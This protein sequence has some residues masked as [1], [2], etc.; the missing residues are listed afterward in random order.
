MDGGGPAV[1]HR[2]IRIEGTVGQGLP[3][4]V[5]RTLAQRRNY[6]LL[7][8]FLMAQNM[9]RMANRMTGR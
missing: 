1:S 9:T 4:P 2:F 8:A 7:L 5:E 6:R 3:V